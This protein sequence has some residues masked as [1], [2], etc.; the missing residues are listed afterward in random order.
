MNR[1]TG[2]TKKNRIYR[3]TFAILFMCFLFNN[4]VNDHCNE[5][6]YTPINIAF[7]SETDTA[8]QAIPMGLTFQGVGTDSIINASGQF[9]VNLSLDALNDEC[10]YAVALTHVESPLELLTLNS[11]NKL[12]SSD[13]QEHPVKRILNDVVYEFGDFEDQLT[14]V[15]KVDS[16]YVF[17]KPT[18]DTLKIS[19]ER[20]LEFISA[21]CGCM[22]TYTIKQAR[23]IHNK[24]AN[25]MI[26]TQQINNQSYEKHIQLYLENY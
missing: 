15:G 7:Y 21:E 8:K 14:F 22:N 17:R 24:I 12:I 2:N 25:V 23:F 4:C 3:M 5:P 16:I 9:A 13:G 10:L 18:F 19:Y 1:L 6:L 26:H 11:E 20:A